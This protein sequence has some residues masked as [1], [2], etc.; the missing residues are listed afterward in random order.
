MDPP[1]CGS[2]VLRFACSVVVLPRVRR[3]EPILNVSLQLFACE[4]IISNCQHSSPVAVPSRNDSRLDLLRSL[5]IFCSSSA[6]KSG[7]GLILVKKL[8]KSH[9]DAV[10]RRLVV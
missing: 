4:A 8:T 6:S 9:P 1:S 7:K 5:D 2:G 10:C 3:R